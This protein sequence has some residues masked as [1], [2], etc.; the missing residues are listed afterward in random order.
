MNI[1]VLIPT[2]IQIVKLIESLMPESKGKEKF[3]AAMGAAEQ[4]LGAVTVSQNQGT[5]GMAINGTVAALNAA[6]VFTKTE[7]PAFNTNGG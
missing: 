7:L 3:D 5:I 4:V 2:I 1:F 6:Q